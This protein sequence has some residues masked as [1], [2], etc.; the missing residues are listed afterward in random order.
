MQRLGSPP[1]AGD[2]AQTRVD[3]KVLSDRLMDQL[4]NQRAGLYKFRVVFNETSKAVTFVHQAIHKLGNIFIPY[5]VP[6]G[7]Q[8]VGNPSKAFS[9]GLFN[10]AG[11]HRMQLFLTQGILDQ[12]IAKFAEVIS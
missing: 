6:A 4:F 1:F 11:A 3:D 9:F 12:A 7:I 5:L 10:H 8:E 2:D